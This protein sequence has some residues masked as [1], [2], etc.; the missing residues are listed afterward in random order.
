M[1]EDPLVKQ[2]AFDGAASFHYINGPVPV[3]PPD[4]TLSPSQILKANFHF[5]P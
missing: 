3:L 4:G 1:N 2:M 5:I